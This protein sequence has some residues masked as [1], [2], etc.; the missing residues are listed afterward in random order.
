MRNDPYQEKSK[1]D[2]NSIRCVIFVTTKNAETLI[3]CD[4]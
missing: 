1:I 3:V 2:L 4:F